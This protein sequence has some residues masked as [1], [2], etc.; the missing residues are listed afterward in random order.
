MVRKCISTDITALLHRHHLTSLI[1]ASNGINDT[2]D[3]KKSLLDRDHRLSNSTN[4]YHNNINKGTVLGNTENRSAS[5][6]GVATDTRGD[7]SQER[8]G[9]LEPEQLTSEHRT[10]G[11]RRVGNELVTS[12]GDEKALGTAQQNGEEDRITCEN[13]IKSYEQKIQLSK[14]NS[15]QHAR[16]SHLIE[17]IIENRWR[18]T[19]LKKISSNTNLNI[20]VCLNKR[21]VGSSDINSTPH[22]TTGQRINPMVDA[23]NSDNTRVDIR[24]NKLD[25]VSENLQNGGSL[26][27]Q[28]SSIASPSPTLVVSSPSLAPGRNVSWTPSLDHEEG[29]L[30][31]LLLRPRTPQQAWQFQSA[32]LTVWYKSKDKQR[33]S[34]EGAAR[35]PPRRTRLT[36]RTV[37]RPPTRPGASQPL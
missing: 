16:A 25:T 32:H 28:S 13:M 17:E 30:L 10:Q 35:R 2:T 27:D 26:R 33:P 24:E 12:N 19:K 5:S 11:L 14:M 8:R 22:H 7:K 18:E 21:S 29:E 37:T 20:N 4:G 31:V 6:T 36:Y 34:N 3:L 23:L 1:E 9:S 15:N